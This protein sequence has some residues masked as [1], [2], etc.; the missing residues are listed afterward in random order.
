MP[1]YNGEKYIRDAI[2]SILK[3]TFTD[4]EFLIIND[5]S[6]DRS[7]DIIQSYNDSR[8]RVVNNERNLGLIAT[9]NKGFD[10]AQGEY[11]ARMDCDDISLPERL[12]DQVKFM[13]RH[14]EIGVCGTKVKTICKK[15][16][17]VLNYP[18]NS[19]LIKSRFLFGPGIAH[20]SVIFRKSLI[21]KYS[22]RYDP[23]FV[24]AE[25]YEFWIRCSKHF[26]LS[27]ID[28]ILLLYRLHP[29]QVG[30]MYKDIQQKTSNKIRFMQIERLGINPSEEEYELHQD[31]STYKFQ[32]S[33]DFLNKSHLWLLKLSHANKM[34]NYYPEPSFSEVLAE[35]WF[36][37][38]N[39]AANLGLIVWK[40]FWQFP[41]TRELHMTCEQKFKFFIKS[42]IR[43]GSR[44]KH[45]TIENP[46]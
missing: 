16:P 43:M 44:C 14:L 45:I 35:R 18:T 42:L 32:S 11:I 37:I 28:K 46:R 1:V 19:N 40:M 29:E 17:F 20:P 39:N 13:E 3:Q 4:F 23:R 34:N 31:I 21:E 27:N 36:H 30:K 22:L 8:I 15:V 38:C 2:E 24:R 41:L 5:G 25:D 6:T 26:P 9:L 7:I 12:E 10:L 33:K